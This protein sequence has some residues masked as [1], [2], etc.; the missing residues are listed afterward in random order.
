MATAKKLCRECPVRAACE[1]T[2]I[3]PDAESCKSC[4]DAIRRR[5]ASA[6]RA[7]D[8]ENGKIRPHR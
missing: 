8:A 3:R 4:R 2:L 1:G 5:T 7:K 6:K